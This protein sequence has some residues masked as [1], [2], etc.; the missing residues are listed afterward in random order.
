MSQQTYQLQMSL[1][2]EAIVKNLIK[3]F[4]TQLLQKVIQ[5]RISRGEEG[6]K[7]L[8]ARNTVHNHKNR[9]FSLHHY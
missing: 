3:N 8:H 7:I 6:L 5:D 2:E 1:T 9:V 4:V